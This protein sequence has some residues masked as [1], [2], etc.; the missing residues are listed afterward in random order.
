MKASEPVPKLKFGRDNACKLLIR[1]ARASGTTW[2]IGSV[3]ATYR[4]GDHGWAGVN[5][6]RHVVAEILELLE[7]L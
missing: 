2:L 6:R 4:A 7:L 5:G 3:I 1:V